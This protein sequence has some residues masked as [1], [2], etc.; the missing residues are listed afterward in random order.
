MKRHGSVK[1][2]LVVLVLQLAFIGLAFHDGL[3]GI[4]AAQTTSSERFS[5]SDIPPIRNKRPLNMIVETGAAWDEIIPYIHKFTEVTGVPVNVERIASSGVYAKENLE[6][7]SGTGHYDVVYVETSW[8]NEWAPYLASLTDLAR[9]Y[10]PNGV[11]GLE[12]ELKHFS[13][14]LLRAGQTSTGE[15]MVLP[16]Y[17]YQMGMIIRE[18][19]FEH[20][21]E[22]ANFEAQFG[23]P[24]KP[25]TT[26]KELHDQAKFFTRKRGEK[27]M[28]QTLEH[29]VYG[30]AMMA[31][32]YQIND[33][34]TSR[35]WGAGADYAKVERNEKGEVTRFVITKEYVEALKQVLRDY[36]EELQYASPGALT[37]NFDFTSAEQG[38]G[39]AIIQPTQ[40]ASLFTY[41][42]EL[43]SKNVPGAR[44][45]MYPTVGGQPYTGAWSLGVAKDSR[46]QEA[47]YWLVRWLTSYEAQMAIEKD[48]GQLAVRIDV[49]NDPIWYTPE[50]YY[51]YGI[52]NEYLIDIWQKQAQYVDDYW[53]FNSAAAGKIYE[54]Q[55]NVLHKVA[56]G[57]P[58]DDVVE[59]LID[60]TI[61]LQNQFGRVPMVRE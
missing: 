4:A 46:N 61:Q 40:F 56:A 28:G 30:L 29:D 2:L 41:T 23:Y 34:I 18:D 55:I 33:E 37:A 27:L 49:L 60:R 31:G 43:L 25:A 59:E 42:A 19:V 38:E 54:M 53:Y 11:E 9:Q 58:V 48:G 35:L 21:E 50:Y 3:T 14:V 5:L 47:A 7:I 16:F 57:H 24:L 36:V 32:A 6:L 20:P 52:L 17:T 1:A 51:P 15:Q 12:A 26:V 10:D 44:I 22:K 39:R 45:R 8:T 13:P